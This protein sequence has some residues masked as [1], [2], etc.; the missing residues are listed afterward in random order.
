ME[1][2]WNGTPLEPAEVVYMRMML[3]NVPEGSV[4]PPE[5][6]GASLE[7]CAHAEG[8]AAAILDGRQGPSPQLHDLARRVWTAV[9]TERFGVDG[10]MATVDVVSLLAYPSQ[11]PGASRM[12]EL[13]LRADHAMTLG[14]ACK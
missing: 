2:R 12:G 7:G 4:A 13:I 6:L 3:G 11:V 10:S 8:V 1:Y 14:G 5:Q 9:Q